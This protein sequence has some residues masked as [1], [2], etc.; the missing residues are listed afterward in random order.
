MHKQHPQTADR[1]DA[2][3]IGTIFENCDKQPNDS[4][5]VVGNDKGIRKV[6]SAVLRRTLSISMEIRF[7]HRISL[8]PEPDLKNQ[9]A[10]AAVGSRIFSFGGLTFI[11][12]SL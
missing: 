11:S 3:S 2:V 4:G 8:E 5:K 9:S 7:L 6:G 10:G 1:K 12:R